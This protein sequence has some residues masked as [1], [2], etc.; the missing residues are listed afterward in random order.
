MSGT[1]PAAD[2]REHLTSFVEGARWF[3]GKGRPFTLTRV[4]RLGEVP[5][6]VAEGPRVAIDLATLE[7]E[8]GDVEYYQL[9]LAFY[10]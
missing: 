1:G 8:D 3:G 5:G 6:A 4:Q 10:A 2:A 9:P 7:Y